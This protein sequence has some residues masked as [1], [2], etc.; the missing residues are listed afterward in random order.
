MILCTGKYMTL[1]C[2]NL[3]NIIIFIFQIFI[4]AAYQI[5]VVSVLVIVCIPPFEKP[6]SILIWFMK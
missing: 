6:L 5:P 1:M 4:N 3:I 2:L